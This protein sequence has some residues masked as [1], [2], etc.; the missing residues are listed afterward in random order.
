MEAGRIL[1]PMGPK[2][3]SSDTM[4]CGAAEAY[5]SDLE[6]GRPVNQRDMSREN[7]RAKAAARGRRQSQVQDGLSRQEGD[8]ENDSWATRHSCGQ[9]WVLGLLDPLCGRSASIFKGPGRSGQYIDSLPLP[10]ILCECCAVS[11]MPNS[12]L[13]FQFW[14]I[15]SDLDP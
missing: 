8:S 2:Q 13:S 4:M 12:A 11:T 9:D 14:N 5:K 15:Y 7:M 1:C 3:L 6:K 10:L